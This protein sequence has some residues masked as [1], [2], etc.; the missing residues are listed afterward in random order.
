MKGHHKPFSGHYFAAHLK[1][2]YYAVAGC[3][4]AD[5]DFHSFQFQLSPEEYQISL[6]LVVNSTDQRDYEKNHKLTGISKPSI[7]SGLHPS[8]MLP[9][10]LC[11]T[12]S[13]MHLFGLNIGKLLIPLWHGIF[14]C[15]STDDKA[16]WDWATLVGNT[17]Q[18]HGKLVT[19]AKNSFHHLFTVLP[20][21][22]RENI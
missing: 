13:L 18:T 5:F 4:H 15:E 11:F 21:T 14:K 16:T 12:L 6:A 9:I 8:Y 1:P 22:C 19:A 3:N 10:P 7:L 20:E 17:W 2:N